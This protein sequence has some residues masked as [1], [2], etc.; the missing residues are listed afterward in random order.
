MQ[1]KKFDSGISQAIATSM[2]AYQNNSAFAEKKKLLY[3]VKIAN[4][5]QEREA[6]FRLGHQIYLEKGY[7]R[8]RSKEWLIQDYDN[9]DETIV[10]LVQDK[11]QKIAGSLTMVFSDSMALP[12]EKTFAEEVKTYRNNGEKLVEVSRLIISPEYRNAKEILLLL[13]NYMAIFAFHNKK[14]SSLIIEVNPRHK[15]YYQT[16]LHFDEISAEK[17]CSLVQDAPAVLLHLP[18][19]RYQ[20]EVIHCAN[21]LVADKKE[22]SLYPKF[23]KPEQEKLV[24]HYLRQQTSVISM[25][26]KQYFGLLNCHENQNEILNRSEPSNLAIAY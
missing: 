18:L 22:R 12:A 15:S 14:Y 21:N 2:S 16:L 9:N 1:H 10:L 19:S 13:M 5:L 25:E 8:P 20:S 23:L 6:V 24:S 4:S 3:T 17:P 11:N 7:I 26:E